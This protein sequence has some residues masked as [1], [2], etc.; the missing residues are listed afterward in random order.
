IL[1]RM[2]NGL[3][4]V[5]QAPG[6]AVS[7][8]RCT[9]DVRSLSPNSTPRDLVDFCFRYTIRPQQVR[10][11]LIHLFEIVSELHPENALEVGTWAGGTL[12]MTCRVAAPGATVISVD[13]PGGRFGRG[14]VWPRRFVYRSFAGSNQALHLLRRD[15]HDARTSDLVRSLLQRKQLDF[16]FIDG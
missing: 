7:L 8:L 1:R 16:L 6:S 12:F 3:S 11:E 14:Y 5:A 4:R 10:E 15:S 9:R 2:R 13:L